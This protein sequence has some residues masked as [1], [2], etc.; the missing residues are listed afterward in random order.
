MW[1]F[2]KLDVYTLK[3]HTTIKSLFLL[4]VKHTQQKEHKYNSRLVSFAHGIHTKQKDI[5]ITRDQQ[6]HRDKWKTNKRQKL[7]SQLISFAK[8]ATRAR[9]WWV[10]VFAQVE[11]HGV[12]KI[13]LVDF[14]H[15]F[16]FLFL[17]YYI[18]TN[19][20]S[21]GWARWTCFR[22]TFRGGFENRK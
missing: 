21:G 9:R 7:F 11:E 17:H 8:T 5:N 18:E 3:Q 14:G 15:C 19:F 20:S 22:A 1:L 12:E 10:K 6:D 13:D 16:S 4:H 2:Y